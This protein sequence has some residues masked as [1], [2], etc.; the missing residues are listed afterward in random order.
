MTDDR[1]ET[2]VTVAD[3]DLPGARRAVHFQEH[4]VRLH[5]VPEAFGITWV[6]IEAALPAPGALAAIGPADL[7]LVAPSN[8]VVSIGP[9]LAVPG[10][11]G[12]LQQASAPV[13]G[14]SGIL[15]G[16]PALGMAIGCCL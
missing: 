16:A 5:A 13:V 6:G 15:G 14:F 3:P 12:A 10:I 8:P 11:R 4:W 1:V 2:H 7:I 9:I